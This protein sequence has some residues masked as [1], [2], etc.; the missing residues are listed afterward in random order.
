MNAIEAAL[1]GRLSADATLMGLVTTIGRDPAPQGSVLPYIVFNPAVDSDMYTMG[2]TRAMEPTIYAIKAV[3]E[4]DS[5]KLA[6]D[7]NDRVFALL[8]DYMALAV[9]GRT[10]IRCDRIDRL[11]PSELADGKTYRYAVDRYRIEVQ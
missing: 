1:Y 3:T 10:V 2:S 6:N 4:G 11:E 5:H 9:A 7:I 8:Q